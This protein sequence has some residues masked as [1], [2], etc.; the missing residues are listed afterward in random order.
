MQEKAFQIG[1][2]MVRN[3]AA[4]LELVKHAWQWDKNAMIQY[5]RIVRNEWEIEPD[6]EV[7]LE[8]S[9]DKYRDKIV[10][11]NGR[12]LI[13]PRVLHMPPTK[14]VKKLADMGY[15]YPAHIMTFS[16]IGAGGINGNNEYQALSQEQYEKIM[17]Y[18]R[19]SIEDGYR[20]YEVLADTIFFRTGIGC[21]DE[22][23]KLPEHI[24]NLSEEEIKQAVDAYEKC[25]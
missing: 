25:A 11:R 18:L 23:Y 22:E 21:K 5:A 14:L 9:L 24:A 10:D 8:T 6:R 16:M 15:G 17:R 2:P 4:M 12:R 7:S 19:F 3:E 20:N 1:I 13:K